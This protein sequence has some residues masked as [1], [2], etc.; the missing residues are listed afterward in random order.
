MSAVFVPAGSSVAVTFA[1]IV[2]APDVQVPETVK[3]ALLNAKFDPLGSTSNAGQ[4]TTP[5]LAK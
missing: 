5:P 4:P 3:S 2:F 1:L